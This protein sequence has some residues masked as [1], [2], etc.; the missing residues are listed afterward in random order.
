MDEQDFQT[1]QSNCNT[2]F[3]P[4]ISSHTPT[5]PGLSPRPSAPTPAT[6]QHLS[7]F[8]Y[9]FGSVLLRRQHPLGNLM[10]PTETKYEPG[11]KMSQAH[12]DP[13]FET[14]NHPT[15]THSTSRKCPHRH[16]RTTTRLGLIFGPFL[17]NFFS[18]AFIIF[19]K[20]K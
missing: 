2:M 15:Q 11:S 10:K 20:H 14:V 18:P 4:T 5:P 3:I 8:F 9:S 19:G 7:I 13:P 16:N 1:L 17:P 6:T 12:P